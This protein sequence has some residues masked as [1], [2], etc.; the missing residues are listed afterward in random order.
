MGS[1]GG[2]AENC[3]GVLSIWISTIYNSHVFSYCSQYNKRSNN[4]HSG[5]Y[6]PELFLYSVQNR[7][8]KFILFAFFQTV[9]HHIRYILLL[10]SSSYKKNVHIP[11]MRQQ[12]NYS[13]FPKPPSRSTLP[14]RRVLLNCNNTF[15]VFNSSYLV[16]SAFNLSERK[17]KW[18]LE[19]HLFYI[20]FPFG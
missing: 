5:I 11:K 9:Y 4:L 8:Y 3:N 16:F 2:V 12:R 7:I 19:F 13:L 20:C 18:E 10:N 15:P 1:F 17:M 14:R 6:L